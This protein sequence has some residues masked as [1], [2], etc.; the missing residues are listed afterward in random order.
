MLALV[1]QR[2]T[3][4][5]VFV[6]GDCRGLADARGKVA[7]LTATME[8]C[9]SWSGQFSADRCLLR[10]AAFIGFFFFGQVCWLLRATHLGG[11]SSWVLSRGNP[12]HTNFVSFGWRGFVEM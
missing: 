2:Q 8:T 12:S 11:L 9:Y 5:A 1:R 6:S 4:L 7:R 10:L 3:S